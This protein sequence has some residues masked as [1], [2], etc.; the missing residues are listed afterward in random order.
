[1]KELMLGNEAIALGAYEGNT[2]VATGYPGTPSSEIIEVIGG[3]YP[4]INSEWSV[5]EK[6]ALE[7]AIGSSIAGMRSLVTMKHVGLNV[8][9]DPL[10]TCAYTGVSAGLVIVCADDPGMH[11]SQNEQ[12][13]RNYAKFAQVPL[14]EPG[15]SQ[16]AKDFT[17]LAFEISEKFD[18]PVIVRPVT[19][20][21]H[22]QTP[23]TPGKAARKLPKMSD[24]KNAKKYVMIPANARLRHTAVIE[25]YKKLREYSETFGG[26]TTEM[27]KTE[28]GIVTH[29]YIYNYVKEALPDASI[30]NVG[31]YPIPVAKIKEF[32]SKVKKLYVIE[33]LDPIIE[34]EL[35][36]AGATLTGKEIIPSE[37]ELSIDIIKKAFG[38][39]YTEAKPVEG[40][41]PRPP[42]LCKGCGHI[43]VFEVLRD[44]GATVLGDIGCY[45]LGV[46]PP[47]NAMHTTICMGSSVGNEIG[48]KKAAQLH[49]L[50]ANSVAV[51]GD[52]TFFH[53]GM[54]GLLDAVYNQ[55]PITLVILDN[56]ITA[57][58]GHQ[59]S[60]NS[61]FSNAFRP[62]RRADMEQ[63]VRGLGVEHVR[64]IKISPRNIDEFKN[65]VLEELA[66]DAPSVIIADEIC[67][68]SEPRMKKLTDLIKEGK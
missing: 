30:F 7:I 26:H 40:L 49:N 67:V 52:S 2:W 44:L 20:V 19:R 63:V 53:S 35:R 9:A 10:M 47:Y 16:E 12:D 1:M 23:V 37:G 36:I 55:T 57:M 64:K 24:G 22:T 62:T 31:M 43:Q 32:A 58:T 41:P 39:K 33:E 25:R 29:G 42:Q 46:L 5:N 8:A 11:S 3:K 14:L 45:T 54:T 38:I 17:A 56:R 60:P 65:A 15:D 34:E 28:I 4:E 68:I 59:P 27:N 6:V 61:G 51:I 18:T 13:T 66:V 50:K 48:Y 21:S